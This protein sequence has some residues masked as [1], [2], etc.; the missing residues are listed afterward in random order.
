MIF[1]VSYVP[2]QLY[3]S[4]IFLWVIIIFSLTQFT[5]N[6]YVAWYMSDLCSQLELLI[7]YC[8]IIYKISSPVLCPMIRHLRNREMINLVIYRLFFF[9]FFKWSQSS[10]KCFS[11][12]K[13]SFL[14]A[15]SGIFTTCCLARVW[16]YVLKPCA[17]HH[18]FHSTA[19]TAL[20]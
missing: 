18:T 1:L 5:T 16:K 20:C 7:N 19:Y 15:T 17:S 6:M 8:F 14:F 9:F 13:I 12:F 2:F 3:L 4:H 11:Y 10:F